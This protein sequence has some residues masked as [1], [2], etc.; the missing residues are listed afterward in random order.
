MPCQMSPCRHVRH[1][2]GEKGMPF[3]DRAIDV[4][5]RLYACPHEHRRY[6][7]RCVYAR[8]YPPVGQ[9]NA[10]TITCT[11]GLRNWPTTWLTR[12]P[13]PLY[14]LPDLPDVRPPVPKDVRFHED[15]TE[16]DQQNRTDSIQKMF[17][18]RP[19][20]HST[21]ITINRTTQHQH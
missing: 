4:Y 12:M 6:H 19:T 20:I 9:I 18:I 3:S 7:R 15:S 1:R 13:V 14:R 10:C 8:L 2:D 5:N 17:T 21:L 11:S 16:L